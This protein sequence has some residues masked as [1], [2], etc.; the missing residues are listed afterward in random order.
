M[1]LGRF[2]A[3]GR[4]LIGMKDTD[5]RYQMRAENLLPK[6]GSAKNPFLTVSKMESLKPEL[7]DSEK[8]RPAAPEAAFVGLAAAPL[9]ESGLKKE[10]S[11]AA[12]PEA[13]VFEKAE[14]KKAEIAPATPAA[15]PSRK[16]LP[17][18]K[19]LKK[20]NVFAY[21][22]P[23][24]PG[25]KTVKPVQTHIQTELSLEKVRVVRNDLSETDLEVVRVRTQAA[26]VFKA[27]VVQVPP[28]VIKTTPTTW[29]RLTSRIFR[30]EETQIR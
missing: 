15:A 30:P 18:R 16:P 14:P 29:G 25:G 23:L 21:L 6:F 1:S 12:V 22:S 3:A 5:S 10:Q 19:W 2:L 17:M 20:L 9:V 24:M 4:S 7:L 28:V 13:V 27:P 26:D 8:P 11:A